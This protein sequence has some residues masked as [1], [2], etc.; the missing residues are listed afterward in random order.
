MKKDLMT[1]SELGEKVVV[2]ELLNQLSPSSLLLDGLGHDA[3]FVSLD[4]GSDEVLVLNTDRSGENLAHKLGLAGPEV[5]GDLAVAHAVSDVVAAGGH[6]FLLTVCLLLPGNKTLGYAK[7]VMEGVQNAADRWGL[8][9]ASGDTKRN[10]SVAIVVT[11]VG[12]AKRSQRLLRSGAKSGDLLVVTGSLGTMF[13]A[14]M[15]HKRGC[16]IPAKLKSKLEQ[17]LTRQS[18]PVEFALM[19]N[20]MALANACTD[21]SD[22]LPGAIFDMCEASD[23]GAKIELEQI[24]VNKD[25]EEFAFQN[26]GIKKESLMAANGD[27]Q[28][29]YAIP[30][31][32]YAKIQLVAQQ[33]N[34]QISVVGTFNDR[35]VVSLSGPDGLQYELNRVQNDGFSKI[36]GKNYFDFLAD[37]PSIFGRPVKEC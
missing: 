25:I 32:H 19:L 31:Q 13:T 23:V 9:L 30:P 34:A 33:K 3:G 7:K 24:P 26:L 11:V 20:S 15:A 36:D 28:F 12:K 18:P 4:L 1:L 35:K 22:G 10:S 5:V 16:S 37:N 27:W 29:L 2:K 17:A 8:I 6:P 14:A 21:I